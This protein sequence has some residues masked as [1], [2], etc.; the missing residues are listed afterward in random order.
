VNGVMQQSSLSTL[1][2]ASLVL[3]TTDL[4]VGT[5]VSIGV[6][7]FANAT[8]DLTVPPTVSAPTITINS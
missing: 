6:S 1:T 2:T 8:S 7:S 4:L 3:D 5:P